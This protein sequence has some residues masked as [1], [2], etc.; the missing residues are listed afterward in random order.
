MGFWIT[1]F[2]DFEKGFHRLYKGI[3]GFEE[4]GSWISRIKKR[5]LR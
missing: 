3:W 4:F 5:L 2:A 1:D